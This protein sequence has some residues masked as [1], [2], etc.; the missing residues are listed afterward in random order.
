[1]RLVPNETGQKLLT[2]VCSPSP[3]TVSWPMT[4]KG[5]CSGLLKWLHDLWHSL[6]GEAGSMC[7]LLELD[8]PVLV[9]THGQNMLWK[10]QEVPVLVPLSTAS[11]ELSF[12]VYPAWVPDVGKFP[13]GKA[14][15]PANE[16]FPAEAQTSGSRDKPSSCPVST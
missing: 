9:F 7:L 3:L 2:S 14:S 8:G 12:S 13:A 11:T 6:H 15:A 1:M 5:A 4:P 16:F 10:P